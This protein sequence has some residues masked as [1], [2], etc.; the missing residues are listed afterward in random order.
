MHGAHVP[1]VRLRNFGYIA[2][3]SSDDNDSGSLAMEWRRTEG[4][5]RQREEA[6]TLKRT[7]RIAMLP[8]SCVNGMR[9]T[10]VALKL[11]VF[12]SGLH[13]LLCHAQDNYVKTRDRA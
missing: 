7:E 4:G 3:R 8:S 1:V 6:H 5:E 2:E 11:K 13:S 12:G 10:H 9:C